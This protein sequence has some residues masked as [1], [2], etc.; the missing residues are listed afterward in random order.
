MAKPVKIGVSLCLLGEKVRYDGG[1]KLDRY[2]TDTLSNFFEFV[3]FCPEAQSGLPTPREVM[4]LEGDP[5][6]PRLVTRHTRIDLTGQVLAWCRNKVEEPELKELCGFIFKK[7]SPSC[8]PCQ[9]KVYNPGI[10]ARNGRGLF[11]D[12]VARHFPLIPMTDEEGLGSMAIRENFIERVFACR[13]WRDFLQEEPSTG[14]LVEFHAA[15]KLLIMAHSPNHY[16][17]MGKLVAHGNEITA[18][19]LLN[20]YQELLMKALT[21]HATVSK[22]VN[23][24]QHIMGHFKKHLS[25]NEKKELLDI[26][27]RYHDRQVPLIAPLTLLMRYTDKYDQSY[28]K[29][30][31]YL[32]PLPAKRIPRNHG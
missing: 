22:N 18:D 26:I 3:G 2:I 11:A 7:R 13:R 10:P 9:V 24:L 25:T 16:R 27:N 12:A 29:K 23:V 17:E 30:Q 28:L 31:V 1:H 6:A 20:R 14:N 8:G 19:K 32:N 5:Q 4:R 21:L 15:H